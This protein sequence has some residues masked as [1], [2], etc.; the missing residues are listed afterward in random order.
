MSRFSFFL[1][2]ASLVT[3]GLSDSRLCLAGDVQIPLG[4]VKQLPPSPRPSFTPS[5]QPTTIASASPSLEQVNLEGFCYIAEGPTNPKPG[6]CVNLLLILNDEGGKELYKTRTSSQGIFE[7]SSEAEKVYHIVSGS[8]FY[9]VV[10]PKAV[11]GG[12]KINLQLQQK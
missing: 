6:P 7:F 11:R 10:A 8:P 9:E 3:L 5:T 4:I 2:L 12:T 1:T